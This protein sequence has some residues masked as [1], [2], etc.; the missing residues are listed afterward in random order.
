METRTNTENFLYPST[1][2]IQKGEQKDVFYIF[3]S[4]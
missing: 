3:S 2:Y 1:N 4:M